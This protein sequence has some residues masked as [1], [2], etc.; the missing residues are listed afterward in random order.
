MSTRAMITKFYLK[1][2]D[3]I[4]AEKSTDIVTYYDQK[5]DLQDDDQCSPVE[6]TCQTRVLALG[7]ETQLR[8]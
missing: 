5:Q 4:I 6:N 2:V 7:V 8:R 3:G 1:A